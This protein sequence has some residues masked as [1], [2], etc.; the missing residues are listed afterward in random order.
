MTELGESAPGLGPY[1]GFTTGGRDGTVW[2]SS[3]DLERPGNKTGL[4]P[5]Q[6]EAND[7]NARADRD[8]HERQ[9]G[10]EADDGTT[11][12]SGVGVVASIDPT[13]KAREDQPHGP[14]YDEEANE[15][16]EPVERAHL[17]RRCLARVHQADAAEAHSDEKASAA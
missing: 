14:K 17:S 10:H 9:C 6:Y 15:A 11:A 7:E 13:A 8:K 16:H 3:R 5:V 12:S 1:G 2:S 4:L